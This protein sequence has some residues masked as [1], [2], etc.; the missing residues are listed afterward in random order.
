MPMRGVAL[1]T[2]QVPDLRR[3]DRSL[4]SSVLGRLPNPRR[5]DAASV[6]GIAND[7]IPIALAL[8]PP[9]SELAREALRE[10]PSLPSPEVRRAGRR[11]QVAVRLGAE[12]H[13]ELGVA[14]RLLGLTPTAVA[15]MCI[16]TGARRAIAD[17]DAALERLSR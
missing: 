2:Y 16:V 1:R 15:R 6:P 17:H 11:P 9:P 12:E 5:L 8:P 10:G 13:E 3:I 7:A 4:W 14:A